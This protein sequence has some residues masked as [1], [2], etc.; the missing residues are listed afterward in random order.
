M[1]ITAEGDRRVAP[2]AGEPGSSFRVS[3][4]S[5][6]PVTLWGAIGVDQN[7]C[8]APELHLAP[9]QI[10][11]IGRAEGR[12]VPYLDPTYRATT[13]VPH[14]GRCI[15]LDNG[16]G[17][18]LYVSRAHFMLRGERAGITLINGVPQCGGGI[19]APRNWT[20]LLAPEK[21]NL[22]SCEEYFLVPGL[23]ITI[24]LPNSSRIR[25]EAT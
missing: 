24:L 15:L 14:S 13:I 12:R 17:P 20:K 19:R 5:G 11:I 16:N 23:A 1:I 25:I 2:C 6:E 8:V 21:R 18:D 3:V 4:L 10:V 22:E 9:E 7:T